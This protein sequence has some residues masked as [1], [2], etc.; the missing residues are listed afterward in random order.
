MGGAVADVFSSLL[1]GLGRT[2]EEAA[3][4]ESK[5]FPQMM[6]KIPLGRKTTAWDITGAMDDVFRTGGEN[7]VKVQQLH[8]KFQVAR[9]Q[10]Q[11]KL[12]APIGQ[13]SDAIVADKN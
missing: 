4:G 9:A 8:S 5:E 10:A 1:K 2:A 7:G 13:I 12:Q 6:Q 11:A 3:T